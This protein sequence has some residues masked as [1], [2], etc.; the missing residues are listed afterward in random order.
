MGPASVTGDCTTMSEPPDGRKV[1][2]NDGCE[3]DTISGARRLGQG[4]RAE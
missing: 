4:A 2:D 1:V 3:A